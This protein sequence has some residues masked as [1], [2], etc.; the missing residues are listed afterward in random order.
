MLASGKVHK[1]EREMLAFSILKSGR[2]KC[3]I[4]L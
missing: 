4:T 1:S 2:E 3:K